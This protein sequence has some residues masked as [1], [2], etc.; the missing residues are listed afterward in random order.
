MITFKQKIIIKQLQTQG[1]LTSLK[2]SETRVNL[3][4]L[5]F[6]MN[7]R[8][9][10]RHAFSALPSSLPSY[11]LTFHFREKTVGWS[12]NC[13]PQ[14]FHAVKHGDTESRPSYSE[15]VFSG[16]KWNKKTKKKVWPAS[17][18]AQVPTFPLNYAHTRK[19]NKQKKKKITL[20]PKRLLWLAESS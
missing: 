10:S 7:L 8:F 1:Y 13:I 15:S 19:E 14:W 3:A 6:I 12:D 4:S 9:V 2:W 5:W 18:E 17:E 20:I 11:L 16:R